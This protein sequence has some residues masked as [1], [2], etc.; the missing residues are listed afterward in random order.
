MEGSSEAKQFV[1][2][3]ILTL[4]FMIKVSKGRLSQRLS[5]ASP[6]T[7]TLCNKKTLLK[8][9]HF[10]YY[11]NIAEKFLNHVSLRLL[12]ISKQGPYK[13]ELIHVDVTW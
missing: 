13:F 9:T 7:Y 5:A 3:L 6:N 11:G 8:I 12:K 2:L 4:N 10:Y 1:I